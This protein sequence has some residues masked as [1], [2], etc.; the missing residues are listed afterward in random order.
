MALKHYSHYNYSTASKLM[1]EVVS[2]ALFE[3]HM[4]FPSLLED[5]TGLEHKE[6]LFEHVRSVSGLDGVTPTVGNVVQKY[7]FAE[8]HY[9]S[10]GPDKTSLELTLTYTLNLNS[11][12]ENYIY[13]LLRK[14]YNLIYNPQNGETLCKSQ[15]A[16]G[17]IMDI[18]EHDRDGEVWRHIRCFNFFPSTPPTGL[19]EDNY[20]SVGDAKTVSITFMVDDWVEHSIGMDEYRDINSG[21]IET[22]HYWGSFNPGTLGNI[23]SL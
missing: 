12:H 6:I 16:G 19:N 23:D 18:Y 13:N 8:R 7:K 21:D 17:S 9:A 3:V 2:P 5:G 22:G 1:Y 14:W 4:R 10:A 11:A 15:Y 20:D